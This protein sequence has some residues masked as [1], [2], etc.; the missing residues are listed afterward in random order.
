MLW[1]KLTINHKSRSYISFIYNVF[2]RKNELNRKI[3]AKIVIIKTE[4]WN[5]R[6]NSRGTRFIRSFATK[7][8]RFQHK[9]LCYVAW[10]YTLEHIID[11]QHHFQILPPPTTTTHLPTTSMLHIT[12]QMHASSNYG[13]YHELLYN[14]TL[15]IVFPYIILYYITYYR[16]KMQ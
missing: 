15:R 7:L 10:K 8:S 6:L 13:E 12:M 5:N 3:M 2:T 9:I 11:T 14:Y 1:G 16:N 4:K